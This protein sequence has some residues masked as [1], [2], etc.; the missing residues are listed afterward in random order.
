VAGALTPDPALA[1]ICALINSGFEVRE[2]VAYIGWHPEKLVRS[3]DVYLAL[4]PLHRETVFRTLVLN[5]RNNTYHCKHQLCP[6]ANPAD[7]VDLLVRW[8]QQPLGVVLND[9]MEHFDADYFRLNGKQ[10]RLIRLAAGLDP[11]PCP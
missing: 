2:L 6:G 5:P 7:F 10:V 1:P 9:V 4:C 11:D 3:G 8:R